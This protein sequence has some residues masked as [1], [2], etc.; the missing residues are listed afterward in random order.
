MEKKLLIALPMC[1]PQLARRS[2]ASS[3]PHPVASM[4]AATRASSSISEIE[5]AKR[6][7]SRIGTGKRRGC[8]SSPY[9]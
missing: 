4:K 7:G 6:G 9:I 5:A 8:G 2:K 1:P 3:R